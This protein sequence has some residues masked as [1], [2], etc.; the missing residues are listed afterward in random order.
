MRYDDLAAT[1]VGAAPPPPPP[2]N[3]APTASFAVSGSGL[4]TAV[5]GTAS[6]DSDGT[7]VSYAWTFGDGGSASGVTASHAYAAAGTYPVTLTVTD[8]DGATGSVTRQVTVTAPPPVTTLATD[9]FGRSV[10]GGWGSADAGGAWT[11]VGGATRFSVAGGAGVQT[12]AAG[13]T[14][15]ATLA[16]VSSSAIDVVVRLSLDATPNGAVYAYVV[17][18]KVGSADYEARVKWSPGGAVELHTARSTAVLAGGALAGV[19]LAAGEAL[20]VRV[21]VEGTSPT[22]VRARAWKAGTAE[23]ATWRATSTDSTAGLQVAGGVGLST[24]LSSSTTS[25]QLPVRY[26]DL[27]ATRLG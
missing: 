3:V 11:V 18:R 17:G 9:A 5:D 13:G 10:T 1:P 23:P 6:T 19:T 15:S 2:P 14:T 8:D 20:L 7:V 4:T 24:Y 27:S 26:D 16:G 25:G 22:T 12:V 21:Q